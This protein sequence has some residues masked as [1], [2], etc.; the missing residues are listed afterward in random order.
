MGASFASSR[1]ARYDLY[2]TVLGFLE[3]I[4]EELRSLFQVMG[5]GLRVGWVV[6]HPQLIEPIT[7]DLESGAQSASAAAQ[8]EVLEILKKWGQAGWDSQVNRIQHFYQ[9]RAARIVDMIR[10]YVDGLVEFSEPTG[11]MFIW[12]KVKG[13]EDTKEL[14]ATLAV[15]HK[16]LFVPGAAFSPNNQPSPYIRISYSL[17]P[18][19]AMEDA[20]KRFGEVLR[21][22]PPTL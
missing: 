3:A 15:E 16:I 7:F 8:L 18:Y 13:I 19:D 17:C 5:I 4:A 11:S 22:L 10:R 21:K 2:H 9:E 14:V 1:L 6:G 20:I 12:L